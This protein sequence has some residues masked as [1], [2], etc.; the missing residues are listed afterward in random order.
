VVADAEV[1]RLHI[2]GSLDCRYRVL[3]IADT[4]LFGLQI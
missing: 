2:Q 1:F 3:S 4:G